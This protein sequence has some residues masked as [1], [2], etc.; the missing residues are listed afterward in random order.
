MCA[1]HVSTKVKMMLVL[2]KVKMQ[3]IVSYLIKGWGLNSGSL[4]DQQVPL[5]I[6]SSFQHQPEWFLLTQPLFFLIC[7]SAVDMVYMYFC[8]TIFSCI[9][10]FYYLLDV[11]H[12]R[13][14]A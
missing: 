2:L 11:N 3:M 9:S 7:D 12:K 6:E 8:I 14:T 13:K 4:E 5:A 10:F 1:L